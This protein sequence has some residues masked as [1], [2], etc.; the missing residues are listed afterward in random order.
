MATKTQTTARKKVSGRNSDPSRS[1]VPKEPA[2]ER[3]MN[4]LSPFGGIEQA[5][6]RAFE[7]IFPKNW[8]SPL[9]WELPYWGDVAMP[10]EGKQPRVDVIDHDNN[11]IVKAELPGMEKENIDIS[12]TA[13]TVTIKAVDTHKK[14]EE[15]G[16]YYRCEISRGAFARTVLLPC[17]VD[18]S[19]AAANFNN[20]I[21][22]L[23]IPKVEKAKRRRITIQ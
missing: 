10:F 15:K 13:N 3:S 6:E 11:V 21:L 18:G 16:E 1:T 23:S 12:M 9:R 2:Q 22:E 20:G 4:Q 14:E 7:N 8:M 19:K 5:F 17:D